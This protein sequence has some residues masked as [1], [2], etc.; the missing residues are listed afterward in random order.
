MVK[1]NCTQAMTGVRQTTPVAETPSWAVGPY[2]FRGT[3][4]PP[5][6]R[7]ARKDSRD[8]A[9]DGGMRSWFER[10]FEKRRRGRR[11]S[12]RPREELRA[13]LL[14]EDLVSASLDHMI[15]AATDHK[16]FPKY[17]LE[18]AWPQRIPG[19]AAWD[20]A[21]EGWKVGLRNNMKSVLAKTIGALNTP[22]TAQIDE[23]FRKVIGLEKMSSSWSWK[24][25]SVAQSSVALDALVTLRGSIAHRVSAAKNVRLKDVR[26]AR[27]LIFRLAVRSHNRAC[28]F[29]AGTVGST[30][31][32]DVSFKRPRG[33]A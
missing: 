16:A 19:L 11:P 12:R 21:G 23:L 3:F 20:L 33:V 8:S 29:L 30:P 1:L 22:R 24:G 4:N 15:A 2:R 18:P 7:L 28:R 31:W 32:L 6:R 25:R 17:V 26:E 27:D 9:D 10:V 13:A 14:R 5:S